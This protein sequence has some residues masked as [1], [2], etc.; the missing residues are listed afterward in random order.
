MRVYSEMFKG[1]LIIQEKLNRH[2]HMTG[3]QIQASP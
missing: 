2:R 3:H 1:L